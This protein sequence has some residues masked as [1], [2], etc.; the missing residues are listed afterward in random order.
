M[1]S[2]AVKF[3]VIG[4]LVAVCFGLLALLKKAQG[5]RTVV[6]DSNGRAGEASFSRWVI[7]IARIAKEANEPVIGMLHEIQSELRAIREDRYHR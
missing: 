3:G 6:A 1:D 7:E 5:R 4:A 2:D